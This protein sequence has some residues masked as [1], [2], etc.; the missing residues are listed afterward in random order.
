ML[1]STLEKLLLQYLAPYVDGISRDK[2]HFGVFSGSLELKDLTIKPEA[3]ALLGMEGFR[4]KNGRISLITLI[5][6]W[7]R[8]YNGKISACVSGVH[9][10]VEQIAES[11]DRCTELALIEEMREGKRQAIDVR[12]Q[13]LRE[14]VQQQQE[15]GS[16][17]S[18]SSFTLKLVRKIVNNIQIELS[19]VQLSFLNSKRG[20]ALKSELQHL[21]MLSTDADFK[22][23]VHEEVVVEGRSLY[24]LLHLKGANLRMAQPTIAQA[25]EGDFSTA[26]YVLSPFGA[27][28]QLAH[29]P[30]E[31]TISMRLEVATEEVAEVRVQRSQ[32]KHLRGW[33]ATSAAEA[34]R[35]HAKMVPPDEGRSIYADPMVSKAEYRELFEKH[36]L[37][38]YKLLR[39][40]DLPL[41][42]AE[43]KRMELLQ[44]ALSTRLLARQRWIVHQKVEALNE[45]VTRRQ[46]EA[47]EAI[48]K[49]RNSQKSY[50]QRLT[51]RWR[52][53]P[54]ANGDMFSEDSSSAWISDGD[55]EQLL[56]DFEDEGKVETVDLPQSYMIEFA[57]GKTAVDLVDDRWHDA[58]HR[59]LLN[60]SLM[61][62]EAMFSLDL[63]TDHRGQDSAEWTF[64]SRIKSFDARHANLALFSFCRPNASDASETPVSSNQAMRTSQPLDSDPGATE[65]TRTPKSGQ[66]DVTRHGSDWLHDDNSSVGII[67]NVLTEKYNLLNL[68]FVFRPLV[69]NWPAGGLEQL[70]E[71]IRS[72]PLPAGFETSVEE[73]PIRRGE[74]VNDWDREEYISYAKELVDTHG[75]RARKVAHEVYERI[76]EMWRLHLNLGS[77]IIHVPVQGM[78]TV[79]IS[80]G[81]LE[82]RMAEPCT[83]N[84]IKI[85]LNLDNTALRATSSRGEGF[86]MIP[87]VPIHNLISYRS[88]E[89]ENH[90]IVQTTVDH[91][92][93]TLAPQALQILLSTPS[94]LA[95]IMWAKDMGPTEQDH[96][97]TAPVAITVAGGASNGAGQTVDQM[98]TL[99]RATRA[100]TMVH[101]EGHRLDSILGEGHTDSDSLAIR[102]KRL[103]SEVGGEGG[104]ETIEAARQRVEKVRQKQFRCNFSLGLR[105]GEVTLAD[106]ILP[107]LRLRTEFAEPGLRLTWQSVPAMMDLDVNG[108][109]EL[110]IANER[111]GEWEPLFERI[112]LGLHLTRIAE[113]TTG[114]K[115]NIVFSGRQPLLV[116]LTPSA[117]RRSAWILPQFLN[118]L[119]FSSLQ[120]DTRRSSNIVMDKYRVVNLCDDPIELEFASKYRNENMTQVK[121]T[122]SRWESL[123]SWILPCFATSLRLRVPGTDRVAMEFSEPLNIE[124]TGVVSIPRSGA[125]AEL[126]Q[127]HQSHRVLL[128][129]SPLR[130]HNQ[131]DLALMI[132][133]HDASQQEVL[134]VELND[135][136]ACDAAQLGSSLPE[137]L[138]L[139]QY[140]DAGPKAKPGRNTLLLPPNALCNVPAPALVRAGGA[141]INE[142]HAWMSIRPSTVEVDFC[143]CVE[144]GARVAAQTVHCRGSGRGS[145]VGSG[146]DIHFICK[147][148]TMVYPLPSPMAVTTVVLRPPLALLNALPMGSL[149]VAYAP[150][151]ADGQAA[152]S[153]RWRDVKVPQFARLN[154][155]SFPGVL[156]EGICVRARIEEAAPWSTPVVLNRQAW[157]EPDSAQM[158]QVCQ[159]KGGAFAGLNAEPCGINEIRFSCPYWLVDRTSLDPTKSKIELRRK[160]AKLPQSGGLWMLPGDCLEEHIEIAMRCC[161]SESVQRTRLP[162]SFCVLPWMTPLGP[163]VFCVQT[164][165]VTPGDVLGAQC[166]VMSLRPRLLLTNASE[167][168]L[169]LLFDADRNRQKL[170]PGASMVYHF[171]VKQGEEDTPTTGLHFR[172]VRQPPCQ[173]SDVVTCSDQAAGSTPFALPLTASRDPR[174]RTVGL[175]VWSVDVAPARGALSVIF[176]EGS[177]F[178]AL[179]KTRRNAMAIRPS[180]CE[181]SVADIP[182]KSGEEVS[183]GWMRPFRDPRAVEVF[184]NCTWHRID[185]VRRTVCHPLHDKQLAITV[186]RDGMKTQ[187]CLEHHNVTGT[188]DAA[189]ADVTAGGR[190]YQVEVKLARLGISLIE[191]TPTPRELL[192]LHLELIRLEWRKKMNGMSQLG[193]AISEAQVDCQLPGR[194]DKETADERRNDSLA[195]LKQERPAVILANCGSGDRAFLQ[196]FVQRAPASSQDTILPRADLMF[197]SIDVTVDDGWLDPLVEF[198]KNCK[199]AHHQKEGDSIGFRHI[200]K[201]AGKSILEDYVVPELPYTMQVDNFQIS[202]IDLTIWCVLKLKSVQFLPPYMRTAIRV[203]S[204]S[205]QLKLDG[206]VVSLPARN[207][208]THR[209]SVSD[210]LFGLKSEYTT[211]LLRAAASVLG[212]SSV[213]NLPRAPIKIGGTALSYMSDSVGL[214]AGEVSSVLNQMTFDDEYVARQQQ[215]R[216]DKK[217][218]NV[219]EGFVEAG[220]SIAQGVDG[221]LDVIKKPIEGAKSGGIGGFL[222]GVGTGAL[223]T[224]VKPISKIGQAVQDVG[225][226]IAASAT[227]DTASMKRR[228]ARL[229]IR[230]P[231]LLFT[232][233]GVVRPWSELEAEALRQLGVRFTHGVMELI[234]IARTGEVCT[235]L[236]LY[237]RRLAI[238]S[239]T[240]SSRAN[241]VPNKSESRRSGMG[242]SSSSSGVQGPST[243]SGSDVFQAIDTSASKLFAQALKPVNTL[244]YGMQDSYDMYWQTNAGKNPREGSN[245][246][247]AEPKVWEL[248][249]KNIRS[250]KPTGSGLQIGFVLA[251]GGHPIDYG[252]PGDLISEAVRDA[253]EVGFNAA[254]HRQDFVANWDELRKVLE[255]ERRLRRYESDDVDLSLRE[256][257]VGQRVLEVYELERRIIGGSWQTPF[258]PTD[259]EASWRWV[260]A[261]GYRHP[262]LDKR[263]RHDREKVAMQQKPPCQLDSLFKPISEWA[264]VKGAG[265]DAQGW[266]YG[267]AWISSTWD[268][269]PEVYHVVRKRR[270]TRTYT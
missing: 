199:K 30:D 68:T 51:S 172:P 169:E 163:L 196:M 96:V 90:V 102:L 101:E 113:G 239:F 209:G 143:P 256:T 154:I 26:E 200:S 136:N 261:A 128:I 8:L 188:E 72:P 226:G 22:A 12:V 17:P 126:L 9:L 235:V 166:Q 115:T 145:V 232:E 243:S 55:R 118:S 195:L 82:L 257:G 249:F 165:D 76:P 236:M 5:V 15:E 250:V 111:N 75:H 44:D 106:S 248:W 92:R 69:I 258:M 262:H 207:L 215:L 103:A 127:P 53:E 139:S 4:V 214:F 194:T 66:F 13:Q 219:S 80:L 192:Y 129:A 32:I 234:L 27:S 54:A 21:R 1:E 40:Q 270:W 168:V 42:E 138:F 177:E 198:M 255:R 266:R 37:E 58:A 210:F 120:H 149:S 241:L 11:A 202:A 98:S 267:M 74:S 221:L 28:L 211:E 254:L 191:E 67:E 216:E 203:M 14:L 155:Y 223:G 124:R 171:P 227:P 233:L 238:A 252:L 152:P 259:G 180:G 264:V 217:I 116:N 130:V 185:D 260:D 220:K 100:W 50:F 212:K 142:S 148:S 52:S 178:I 187:L 229:R 173:W 167:F 193:L 19:D 117:V 206:A 135:V 46:R 81:E 225:S 110:G 84:D 112:D 25:G 134:D 85:K 56:S 78:G 49:Q 122:G 47:E 91:L 151:G 95:S 164:E 162:P 181:D 23:Q 184:V 228:R 114:R 73:F 218:N 86:D 119:T 265:A 251:K 93:I 183:F 36:L 133:F 70:L 104:G 18:D 16:V 6:D 41:S 7:K 175:E 213:L 77:P 231:R 224:V 33:M 57:L 153:S 150:V 88:T 65:M 3:L 208:P 182:V 107:V 83:Y 39:E 222:M 244:A 161:G 62:A 205:N 125:V 10:E 157:E 237:A 121:P 105:D 204:F 43:V 146:K 87:S 144:V 268:A 109:W 60:L 35:L 160:G 38:K 94:A 132:R 61:G 45:E 186:K 245:V 230:Q 123:D 29:K 97:S 158:L 59:Q 79:T 24:K 247:A 176:R 253:L 240:L 141:D 71:F 108:M 170:R 63:K 137:H 89:E 147:S 2:L 269:A 189:S 174:K 31:A 246:D 64:K 197:D 263:L 48:L 179:N 20:L 99:Q 201:I 156:R 34:A 190:S 242:N 131:T 140:T 159:R